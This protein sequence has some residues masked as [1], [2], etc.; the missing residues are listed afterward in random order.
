MIATFEDRQA[1]EIAELR[2]HR[3]EYAAE[4][5]A[6]EDR[7]AAVTAILQTPING[8]QEDV[9]A[10]GRHA[11]VYCRQHMKAHETGWCSV[12]S[13]DKVG[14]GVDTADA[15][16]QKCR[17]WGLDLYHDKYPNG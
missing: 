1:A 15:A 6:L 17:E 2:A 11:W 5:R 10:F 13:R 3:D 12:S 9:A 14:L 7:I 8:E 4:K 16:T